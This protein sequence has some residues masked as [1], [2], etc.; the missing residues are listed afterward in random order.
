MKHDK[1][2]PREARVGHRGPP[3]FSAMTAVALSECPVHS[4]T[5][6]SEPMT[7]MPTFVSHYSSLQLGL[8]LH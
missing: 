7:H 8:S 4:N 2:I 5:P 1:G 3:A 6:P